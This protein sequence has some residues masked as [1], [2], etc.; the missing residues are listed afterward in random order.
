MEWYSAL[1]VFRMDSPTDPDFHKMLES[2]VV[3]R[4]EDFT[5][6]NQLA[7][8]IGAARAKRETV[9]DD[10]GRAGIVLTFCFVKNLDIVGSEIEGQEVW[11][12]LSDSPGDLQPEPNRVPSQTI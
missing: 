3:F 4:A 2:L 9:V 5:A 1:L 12:E 7:V 8:E 10:S 6:A 11:S